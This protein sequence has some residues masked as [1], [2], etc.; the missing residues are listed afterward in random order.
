M[1]RKE[2]LNTF[3]NNSATICD[4]LK[5]DITDAPHKAVTYDTDGTLIVPAQAGDPAVGLILSDTSANYE[6]VTKAGTEVDVTPS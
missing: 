6:G 1:A 2:Y 3:I 5:A 4:V